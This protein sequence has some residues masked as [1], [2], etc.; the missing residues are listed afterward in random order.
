MGEMQHRVKEAQDPP[1]STREFAASDE[2]ENHNAKQVCSRSTPWGCGNALYASAE[3]KFESEAAF[4]SCLGTNLTALESSP[5]LFCAKLSPRLSMHVCCPHCSV[6]GLYA[7]IEAR[8]FPID[9]SSRPRPE[10]LLFPSSPGLPWA[11]TPA[12]GPHARYSCQ[13]FHPDRCRGCCF[14]TTRACHQHSGR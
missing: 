11:T 10:E 9:L 3:E 13:I 4:L 14:A 1:P 12:L 8:K 2:K 6:S 5:H 7:Q